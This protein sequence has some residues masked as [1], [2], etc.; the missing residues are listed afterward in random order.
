MNVLAD[1]VGSGSGLIVV[2][3][4]VL[5]LAKMDKA[6]QATHGIIRRLLIAL[7]YGAGGLVAFT[8][9]G[10]LWSSIASRI[11]GYFG[12][13]ETG[14]PHVVLVVASMIVILGLVI[15]IIWEPD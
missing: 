3:A 12:G 14:T 10:T 11:A 1:L 15:A 5:I 13:M 2:I 7:N 4:V 8:G 9:L 6:P